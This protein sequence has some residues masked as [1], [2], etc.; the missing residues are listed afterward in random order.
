MNSIRLAWFRIHSFCA[1]VV[2]VSACSD[3]APP[4]PLVG[5]IALSVP[6]TGT[7]I[8]FR[9]PLVVKATP[10]AAL[11]VPLTRAVTWTSVTPALLAVQPLNTNGDSARIR[12]SGVGTG[13]VSVSA[14]GLSRNFRV[15]V[16]DTVFSV[17]VTPAALNFVAG[18]TVSFV[19]GVTGS[20]S[21]VKGVQWDIS[22]PAVLQPLFTL[23]SLILRLQVRSAGQATIRAI[24]VADPTKV[25]SA[26]VAAQVGKLVFVNQ[27]AAAQREIPLGPMP[28]V[29]V[30]D[31]A[32][33]RSLR[34]A[35]DI[36]LSVGGGACGAAVTGASTVRASNGVATFPGVAVSA[37]CL[38][39][40]LSATATPTAE[41]ATSQSF[42][43]T[44]RECGA[45]VPFTLADTVNAVVES[46][47]CVVVRGGRQFFAHT[48][49]LTIPTSAV[50]FR[51]NTLGTAFAPRVESYL[52]QQDPTTYWADSLDAAGTLVTAYWLPPGTH[53]FVVTSPFPSGTGAYT[54]TTTFNP[55]QPNQP[56]LGCLVAT[57]PGVTI[58]STL[59]GDACDRSFVSRP[60]ASP[61]R[62]F[63]LYLRAGQAIQVTYRPTGSAVDNDAYLEV[64]DVTNT[65]SL[66]A[67]NLIGSDDNS[68][69][70]VRGMDAQLTVQPAPNGRFILV[71]TARVGGGGTSFFNLS[72]SG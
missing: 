60:G 27:P 25:A 66:S 13:E 21:A 45:V 33:N 19:A 11:G 49:T 18:D 7:S 54:R 38:A 22:N 56:G 62:H 63:L 55:L 32:G 28:T 35:S 17:T 48:Y 64:F 12:A 10:Q 16:Q 5:S 31:A 2:A 1:A 69:G 59:A 4:E 65:S 30:Q 20:P 40:V 51:L 9:D 39:V 15:T 23:D 6:D 72:I 14:G 61:G 71:R 67:V 47:D 50:G 57:T 46:G 68:G 43:V 34:S 8:R 44:A 52:W 24:A 3:P 41:P 29:E 42:A 36:T 58:S 53:R 70:G 26:T 37:R